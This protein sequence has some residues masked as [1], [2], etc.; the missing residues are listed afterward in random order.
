MDRLTEGERCVV[1]ERLRVWQSDT[2]A[3]GY[4][5]KLS[6]AAIDAKRAA[7]A[8]EIIQ[9]DRRRAPAAAGA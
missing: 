8:A 4:G 1:E 5:E 6:E 9:T 3:A 2:A 7:L